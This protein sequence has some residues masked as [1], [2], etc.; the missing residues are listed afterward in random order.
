MEAGVR[1]KDCERSANRRD[2]EDDEAAPVAGDG[3]VR[4]RR[5][6]RPI[7]DIPPVDGDGQ[8]GASLAV[9]AAASTQENQGGFPSEQWTLTP[10]G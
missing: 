5:R 9:P 4:P 2:S 10:H 6:I 8:Q 3:V 7:S 1:C